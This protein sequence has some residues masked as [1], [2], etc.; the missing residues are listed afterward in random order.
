MS[1][2]NRSAIPNGPEVSGRAFLGI[3]RHIKE[4][5]GTEALQRAVN[6]SGEETARI[7]QNRI[8]HAH[9]YP[10]STYSAFLSSLAREFGEGD[11]DYGRKLG[12]NSGVRDVNTVFRVYLA[13]ASP[14]RLIR[15]CTKVWASYYRNAG[16]MEAISWAP[17]GTTLR[18]TGFPE[19]ARLHCELME[20]WMIATMDA[21]GLVVSADGRETR[22]TSRGDP[23]HEF[24]CTWTRRKG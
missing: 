16:T 21:L 12:A 8:L 4:T 10:Y 2:S 18:I 23:F 11:P 1:Y 15:G 20:G 5:H 6:G 3:I 13:L 22:C 17:T 14:E 9:W 7:F 24:S 19:M